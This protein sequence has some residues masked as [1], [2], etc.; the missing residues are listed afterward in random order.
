MSGWFDYLS[1]LYSEQIKEIELKHLKLST[2]DPFAYFFTCKE[3]RQGIFN[4]KENKQPGL[5]LIL[6]EF[7]KLGSD[8]H[9]L[10]TVKLYL[11]FVHFVTV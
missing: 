6:N 5:D 9:L 2:N 8:I 1:E 7:I 3:V 10:P 11:P 4:L